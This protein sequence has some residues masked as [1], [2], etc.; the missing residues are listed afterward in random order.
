[1]AISCPVSVVIPT[2]KRIRRL[3]STLR[4]ILECRPPPG[5]ILVHVDGDDSETAA[6][7]RQTH[8]EI[9]VLESPQRIGPGGGRNRLITSARHSIVAS[10]DDDSYPLDADYFHRVQAVFHEFPDAS[11]I[12]GHIVERNEQA[13]DAKTLIGSTAHFGGGGAVYRREDFVATSGYLAIPV[14]YGIE[15]VDLCLRM[16]HFEKRIYYCPWLRVFHDS[17]L[18][19]H[20]S[21]TV[22]SASISNLALLIYVRYPKRY[23]AYGILQVL[24]RI[25]WLV[26]MKRISGIGRGVIQIPG[27]IWNFRRQRDPVSAASIRRFFRARSRRPQLRSIFA[28]DTS[29]GATKEC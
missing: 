12:A 16:F 6:W 27:S 21:T 14:A 22:T 2:R 15:E 13:Q 24:N 1:M 26:R 19:H 3:S 11:V 9:R 4:R 7:L 17:D 23:W 20:A 28:H 18:S 10:F 5:E 29:N 8:P 25:W